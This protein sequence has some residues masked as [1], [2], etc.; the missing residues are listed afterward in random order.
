[1]L[2]EVSRVGVGWRKRDK[3]HIEGNR[4]KCPGE[5]RRSFSGVS[6]KDRRTSA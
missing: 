6:R 1:M 2:K 3:E 4:K 5:T